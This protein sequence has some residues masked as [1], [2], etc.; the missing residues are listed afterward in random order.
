MSTTVVRRGDGA[1]ALL[2]CGIPLR[3]T[4]LLFA[5]DLKLHG[6]SVE[7]NGADLLR[8]DVI[9]RTTHEIDT[10]RGNVAIGVLVIRKSQQ[11]AR[12]TDAGITD[13]QELEQIVTTVR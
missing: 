9:R 2:T 6:L 10:N 13:K 5:D 3:V 7:I 1:E 4:P 11:Q 8:H 12:L